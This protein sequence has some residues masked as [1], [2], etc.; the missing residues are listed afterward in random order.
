MVQGI[1]SGVAEVV[2]TGWMS[3]GAMFSRQGSNL[4][5]HILSFID[6]IFFHDRSLRLGTLRRL[7]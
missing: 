3:G 2:L 5:D 4:M 1:C 6:H 7:P